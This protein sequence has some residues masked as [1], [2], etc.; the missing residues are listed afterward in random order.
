MDSLQQLGSIGQVTASGVLLIVVLL[1]ARVVIKGDWM[2]RR[3]VD[4]LLESRDA[5]IN[6]SNTRG[7]EWHAA[8]ETERHR[9]D[10]LADQNNALIEVAKTVERIIDTVSPR[11][12]AGGPS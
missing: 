8:Y 6:R 5:E 11:V 2:P 10:L 12:S 3:T 7:D 1:I 4:L 9:A